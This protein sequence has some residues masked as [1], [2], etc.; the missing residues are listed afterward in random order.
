VKGRHSRKAKEVQKEQRRTLMH[1]E[2]DVESA[3]LEDYEEG[4]GIDHGGE[5]MID[6]DAIILE[7]EVEKSPFDII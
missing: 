6:V 2:N 5:E 1:F 3:L 4:E 7:H